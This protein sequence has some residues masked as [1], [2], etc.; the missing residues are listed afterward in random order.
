MAGC[1]RASSKRLT[2]AIR[3]AL[4]ELLLTPYAAAGRETPFAAHVAATCMLRRLRVQVSWNK[5]NPERPFV[6]VRDVHRG[7]ERLD[8]GGAL[9]VHVATYSP[10][11]RY[12]LSPR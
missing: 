9:L 8:L 3:L 6:S 11:R 1:G 4:R 12:A 5:P 7:L 2:V 10:T